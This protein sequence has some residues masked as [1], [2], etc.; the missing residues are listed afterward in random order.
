MQYR[1]ISGV[2]LLFVGLLAFVGCEYLPYE[3]SEPNDTPSTADSLVSSIARGALSDSN[4]VDYWACTLQNTGNTNTFQLTNLSDD[5]QLMMYV[6]DN[7]DNMVSDPL[8]TGSSTNPVLSDKGGTAIEEISVKPDATWK[9]LL[10]IEPS[11]LHPSAS[12]M[13]H[14]QW[15]E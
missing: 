15:Y 11:S 3:E 9:I 14:L 5:L 10:R 2:L 1:L 6:Y 4:D 12:G 7:S 13:Y 8:N